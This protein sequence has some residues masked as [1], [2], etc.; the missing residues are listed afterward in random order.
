MTN[1]KLT[2]Q[3]HKV[4]RPPRPRGQ[5]TTAPSTP[6]FDT[7]VEGKGNFKTMVIGRTG[8]GKSVF[9][10]D[11]IAQFATAGATH[12]GKENPQ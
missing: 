5:R 1:R 8:S 7:G 11:L 3:L 4:Q 10:S 2:A 12:L 9:L 6:F